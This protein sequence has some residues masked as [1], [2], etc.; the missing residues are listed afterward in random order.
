MG[1]SPSVCIDRVEFLRNRVPWRFAFSDGPHRPAQKDLLLLGLEFSHFALGNVS[2]TRRTFVQRQRIPEQRMDAMP[3][4]LHG[5]CCVFVA[6]IALD[7]A[8]QVAHGRTAAF[9]EAKIAC[10][11]AGKKKDYLRDEVVGAA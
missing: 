8:I 11:I 4:P 2:F 3:M 7:V 1:L 5:V 10:A 6:R 9:D